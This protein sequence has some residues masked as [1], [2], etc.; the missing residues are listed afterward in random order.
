ME[1][2]HVAHDPVPVPDPGAGTGG[3]TDADD[4]PLP[5]FDADDD[6]MFVSLDRAPEH[7]HTLRMSR[8]SAVSAVSA[9]SVSADAPHA[10]SHAPSPAASYAPAADARLNLVLAR[11]AADSARFALKPPPLLPSPDG[12]GPAAAAAPP[13]SPPASPVPLAAALSRAATVSRAASAKS[14]SDSLATVHDQVPPRVSFRAQS[15][16]PLATASIKRQLSDGF[17]KLR[18]K[19]FDKSPTNT[20]FTS[21]THAF[22]PNAQSESSLSSV[23]LSELSEKDMR[24]FVQLETQ[25]L[26][27]QRNN[28]I[29]TSSAGAYS[30][31]S[32]KVGSLV[33]SVVRPGTSESFSSNTNLFSQARHHDSQLYQQHQ[34]TQRSLMRP[35]TSLDIRRP[36][37]SAVTA[38]PTRLPR[39]VLSSNNRD[40]RVAA[41][42]DIRRPSTSDSRPSFD[43]YARAF[44]LDQYRPL[45]LAA[46]AGSDET[47][48]IR[49]AV[50]SRFQVS[51]SHSSTSSRDRTA[52]RKWSNDW[53]RKLGVVIKR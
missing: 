10:P 48:S 34:Q 22:S 38:A 7:A 53:L 9:V 18:T 44:S 11:S 37:T 39:T 32:P 21:P 28:S 5:P 42:L 15:P 40:S 36:S 13:T 1:T 33:D 25:L 43:D 23:S 17:G 52:A 6:A 24:E 27:R 50:R 26:L 16:E 45:P 30:P 47:R 31:T 12:P 19:L 20:A 49:S 3:D 2:D 51:A 4:T 29:S 41:S 46:A 14:R 35:S 8:W